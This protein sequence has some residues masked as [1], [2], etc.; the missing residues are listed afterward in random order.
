MQRHPYEPCYL[1]EAG[2]APLA[3]YPLRGVIWYQG[4]SNAHNVELFETE[5]PILVNS[6]RRAWDDEEMPFHF[7]QLSSIARPSWPHFRDAQRKLAEQI[8]H[9]EM[10]VSSDKGDSLD[11]HPREKRPIGERLARIALHHNYGYKKITSSGPSIR[12]AKNKGR[13]IVLTFDHAKGMSSSDGKA[14]RSF[15]VADEHGLY[16]PADKIEIKG[17]TIRLQSQQVKH[18]TRARYGWQPFTRANLVNSEGLPASTFE[19]RE[20]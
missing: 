8:P 3:G 14:L 1:Y 7:V 5:F 15:E 12:S 2:V 11:V 4:E 9:C 20:Q 13:T 19:V 16:Y 6:W 17:N 18:P 10:A